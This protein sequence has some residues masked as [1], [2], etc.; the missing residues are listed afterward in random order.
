MNK[1]ELYIPIW[2]NHRS[3]D[4]QFDTKYGCVRHILTDIHVKNQQY[5]STLKQTFQ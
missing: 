2:C 5:P 3:Y 4:G 1:S